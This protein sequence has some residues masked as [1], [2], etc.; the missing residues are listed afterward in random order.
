MCY[1]WSDY[2]Q[3][4][5]GFPVSVPSLQAIVKPLEQL[6]PLL[7]REPV[8]QNGLFVFNLLFKAQLSDMFRG[9]GFFAGQGFYYVI[10][11]PAQTTC[12]ASVGKLL[13]V[14]FAY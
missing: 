5:H 10:L 7:K 13:E 4:C 6:I 9:Q 1:I 14:L 3:E 2:P 12:F 8:I 11:G